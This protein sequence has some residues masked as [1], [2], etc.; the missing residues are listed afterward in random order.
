[1]HS[2]P[3]YL[4]NH[5]YLVILLYDVQQGFPVVYSYNLSWE[6]YSIF[7]PDNAIQQQGIPDN[8]MVFPIYKL[9]PIAELPHLLFYFL[10]WS[11]LQYTTG[12]PYC[13]DLLAIVTC[14]LQQG[15]PTTNFCSV[16]VAVIVYNWA[17]L[18]CQ[19]ARNSSFSAFIEGWIE[20]YKLAILK[21]NQGFPDQVFGTT[22]LSAKQILYT[23]TEL[24]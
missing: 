19:L 4:I 5:I 24:P 17:S 2:L 20:I 11:L 14:Y 9:L 10:S 18:L 23:C 16:L 22:L 8:V 13:V 15:F 1:M 12:L 21:F 6:F 3:C 7:Q